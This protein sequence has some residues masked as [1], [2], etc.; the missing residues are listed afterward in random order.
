MQMGKAD[1]FVA[2]GAL[3]V[4]IFSFFYFKIIVCIRDNSILRDR[5]GM[6]DV[7]SLVNVL[8]PTLDNTSVLKS[9]F[10]CL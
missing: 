8:M 5:S 3:R 7:N 10:W 6:M 1:D 4:K 2:I 9:K